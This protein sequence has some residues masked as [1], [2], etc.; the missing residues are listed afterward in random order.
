M[1]KI[2]LRFQ[3][4]QKLMVFSLRTSVIVFIL[5]SLALYG[6]QKF[7]FKA[8]AQS[9]ADQF[10]S[11]S[12]V[13][14][15][16]PHSY[17]AQVLEE[18]D[19]V[20]KQVAGQLLNS[21]LLTVK[22]LSGDLAGQTVKA[23]TA[24]AGAVAEIKFEPGDKVMVE[25]VETGEMFSDERVQ[26]SG[27]N[28]QFFVTDYLRQDSLL[29]L[30]ILFVAVVVVVSRLQGVKSVLALGISFAIV[31]KLILPLLTRGINP[32]L[33]SSLTVL[34]IIP[35]TFYLSHGWQAKTHLAVL[36]TVLALIISV[37][38]AT[39]FVNNAH[40][41][42][43]SSEEAGFLSVEKSGQLDIRG[44]LLASIIIGLLGTL[45]DI[46]VTQASLVFQLHQQKKQQKISNLYRQ[47]MQVGQ[48]H[49]TSMVNTLVLV[50][51]GASLP[52]LLLFN[53]SSQPLW[54]IL[55]QEIVA[56][57]VIRMLIGSIG[58]ILAAPL[59]TFLASAWVKREQIRTYIRFK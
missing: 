57:E 44:L 5:L 14:Q 32:V 20:Q 13:S 50:Y 11:E 18:L 35:I 27:T 6:A 37:F 48:D 33:V 45:D 4:L 12:S 42:G 28:A 39:T 41:S 30:G 21:Q 43:Y 47:A 16:A 1:K 36:G 38:L 8:Q 24:L 9:A 26:D 59:T 34:A 10:A 22:V 52:L 54:V 2:N 46:T 15:D 51:V 58:L 53:T 3:K 29:I 55:N 40:L 23:E 31:V 56:E 25:A 19:Q 17:Q 49:I 7:K